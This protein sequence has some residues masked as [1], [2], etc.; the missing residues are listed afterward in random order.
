MGRAIGKIIMMNLVAVNL[1][2]LHVSPMSDRQTAIR[3]L[4]ETDKADKGKH[5]GNG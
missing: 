2:V 5:E 1:E 4:S 3:T